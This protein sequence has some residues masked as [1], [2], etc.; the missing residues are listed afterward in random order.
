M[1]I[2]FDCSTTETLEYLRV[3]NAI[4]RSNKETEDNIKAYNTLKELVETFDDRLTKV[5]EANRRNVC[6]SM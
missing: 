1:R 4:L 2:T 5:E 6:H 3:V